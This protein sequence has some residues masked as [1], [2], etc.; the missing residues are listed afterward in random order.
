MNNNTPLGSEITQEP[1]P[2]KPVRLSICIPTYNRGAFISET[3]ESILPQCEDGVEVVI[4]DG[5]S[6]DNTAEVV[7]QW[8]ANYPNLI[9]HRNDTNRG[10]D[11]DMAASVEMAHGEYCWLMSSDDLFAP[12]A[13]A[14]MLEAFASNNDIYFCDIALCDI[15]MAPIRNTRFLSERRQSDT[16]NL[17]DRGEFLSYLNLAT[18]NNALFCYMA[19]IA[20]R[21]ARWMQVGYKRGFEGTGYAH[22]LTLLSFIESGCRVQYIPQPLVLNRSDND[23]FSCNGMEARYLLDFNGYRKIADTL[24]SDDLEIKHSFLRVMA[25]EHPWYRLVKLR[26]AIPSQRRW[27]EICEQLLPFGYGR[28]LLALCGLLGTLYPLV[29]L[30]LAI[31]RRF[32]SSKLLERIR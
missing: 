31:N 3:L 24:F 30:S 20:F 17:S 28:G 6:T 29:R 26:S 7:A 11:R 8:A 9:Y 25:R 15:S 1:M 27:D 22:V 16:Y 21:R 12:G 19:C 4:A 2:Q 13:V 10:V 18:S 23:S 5:A 32:S 14:R